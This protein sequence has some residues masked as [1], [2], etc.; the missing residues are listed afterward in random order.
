MS[1][2]IDELEEDISEY[3]RTTGTKVTPEQRSLF[4]DLL[5][6]CDKFTELGAED[7]ASQKPLRGKDVFVRWAKREVP[8]EVKKNQAI[9][10]LVYD[11]Y[12]KGY[13]AKKEVSFN[14]CQNT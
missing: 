5:I 12:T 8:G 9:I 1:K 4:A 6:A 14:G 13:N 7:A 11:C 10:D 3:E 2:M